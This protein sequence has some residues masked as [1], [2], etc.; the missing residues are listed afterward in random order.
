V[1]AA[2][3]DA[4]SPMTD[5]EFETWN[6]HEWVDS[7]VKFG[8]NASAAH[9]NVNA[10]GRS[11]KVCWVA[12]AVEKGIPAVFLW[13]PERNAYYTLGS[14][15]AAGASGAQG[16]GNTTGVSSTS[17]G[18]ENADTPAPP[19]LVESAIRAVVGVAKSTPAPVGLKHALTR[20]CDFLTLLGRKPKD[21]NAPVSVGTTGGADA[22]R[23]A[24]ISHRVA[25]APRAEPER[26]SQFLQTES[27]TESETDGDDDAQ[28][29]DGDDTQETY[30]RQET[31]L[32][33]T[34]IV[35]CQPLG[36]GPVAYQPL[37]PLKVLRIIVISN[38]GSDKS[39]ALK[40]NLQTLDT[41]SDKKKRLT[42]S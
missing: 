1:V 29:D 10:L 38:F 41:S 7:S 31:A 4:G 24:D 3:K 26:V 21:A 20:D 32:S 27:A 9:A 42:T 23:A 36:L 22:A 8:V 13:V 37:L 25:A 2:A 5:V 33:T 16:A 18:D 30:E 6:K 11:W 39:F 14:L 19:C 34:F 28:G 17:A 35:T 40:T 12:E 15:A